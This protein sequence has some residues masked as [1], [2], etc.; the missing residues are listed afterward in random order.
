MVLGI[1]AHSISGLPQ[2]LTMPAPELLARPSTAAGTDGMPRFSSR[3]ESAPTADVQAPQ[4]TIPVTMA[5]TCLAMSSSWLG[6][7]GTKW[8]FF[9]KNL[10]SLTP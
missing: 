3:T 10:D 5:S 7:A 9:W 6:S 1:T 2:A 4:S 8:D